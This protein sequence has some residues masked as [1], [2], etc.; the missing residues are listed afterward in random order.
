MPIN[1]SIILFL[2]SNYNIEKC[3]STEC[4]ISEVCFDFDVGRATLEKRL[5]TKCKSPAVCVGFRAF[6]TLKKRLPINCKL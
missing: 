5:P 2:E 3:S 1:N 6:E 4:K